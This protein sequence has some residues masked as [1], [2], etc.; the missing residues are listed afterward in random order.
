MDSE[1]RVGLSKPDFESSLL[2]NLM[3][4]MSPLM[5]KVMEENHFIEDLHR[6]TI[7]IKNA[8]VL[9]KSAFFVDDKH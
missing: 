2:V 5:E 8:Q 3:T 7:N 9:G 1:T 4:I 6:G